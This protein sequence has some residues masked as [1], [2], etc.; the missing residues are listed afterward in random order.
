[1]S[2]SFA[3]M[4]A[5][6]VSVAALCAFAAGPAAADRIDEQFRAD[7]HASAFRRSATNMR[8]PVRDPGPPPGAQVLR[9]RFGPVTIRPGQ[10]LI[11]VDL[12]KERPNVDGWIVG[13][14][15]GLVDAETGKNP[16]VTK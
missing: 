4:V 2:S 16:P 3:R 1:M 9:Y 8:I 7:A 14:R 5:L 15:P 6:V 11:D 10:N 12:Q 13:F